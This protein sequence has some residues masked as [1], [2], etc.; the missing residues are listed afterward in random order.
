MSLLQHQMQL[1]LSEVLLLMHIKHAV[2]VVD[3]RNAESELFVV[4]VVGCSS[5]ACAM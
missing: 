1:P 4:V 5:H 2:G 3:G